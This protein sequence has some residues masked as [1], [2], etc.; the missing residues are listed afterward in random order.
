ML[1]QRI[2]TAVVLL[3]LALP[4]IFFAPVWV[5]GLFSLAF[6]AVGAAEWSRLLSPAGTPFRSAL[7]LLAAGGLLLALREMG[8]VR[9]LHLSPILI[10][11]SVYW[12]GFA[13]RRLR[14]HDARPGRWP[15]AALL[16]LACWL[17]LYELR[18]LGPEVLLVA[19][20]IVWI[21]DIGAYFAG[22]A[23]GRRKLAPSI[24]P[25]KTWEG[26][27]AGAVLVILTG[28]LAA[29]HEGLAG[30]LPARLHLQLG[31]FAGSM[32]LG[33]IVAL[34]ILG[35]LHESLLKRQAGV[36]D[37]GRSL[38]GHGGV[39]DRIDALLPTMPVV[40]LLHLM[41]R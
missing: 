26:A 14:L 1:L 38:P 15:L 24:S 32:I 39:L 2:L 6:L 31:A 11:A 19:M 13:W 23:F 27:A 12:I 10:A 25:G 3:A 30:A 20:A 33:G 28:A 4:A 37:S 29:L 9:P 36:K 40:L 41:L 7:S 34:S 35:D 16:L 5:W 22:R 17:A 18:R 21:A 8:L